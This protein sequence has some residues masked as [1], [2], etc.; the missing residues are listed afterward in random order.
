MSLL[1]PVPSWPGIP[2]RGSCTW[3][4]WAPPRCCPTRAAWWT[5]ARAASH[6]CWTVTRSRAASTS[7]G[8]SSRCVWGCPWGLLC[9]PNPG[10]DT[11]HGMGW[12]RGEMGPWD[13]KLQVLGHRGEVKRD[14]GSF[15]GQF[16]IKVF[17][18]GS[19]KGDLLMSVLPMTSFVS[20]G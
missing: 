9:F 7:A 14:Q 10:W 5:R 17:L 13:S 16:L 3:G 8:T 18:Y 6:S 11:T 4:P 1:S 19:R 2:R 15:S 20:C 12:D